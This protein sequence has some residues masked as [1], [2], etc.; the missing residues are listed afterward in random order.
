M[1]GSFV[2]PEIRGRR[3]LPNVVDNLASSDPTRTFASIPLSYNLQDGFRDITYKE[4]ARAIDRC[5]WWMEES[6]GGSQTFETLNYVGPQDL[7]YAMLLFAA[8]K[9]GYQV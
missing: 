3:L 2:S 1:N 5:A 9:T 4:F 7:R 8:I 6:L